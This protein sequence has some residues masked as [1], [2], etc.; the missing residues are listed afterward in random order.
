MSMGDLLDL[1]SLVR[2]SVIMILRYSLFH[3]PSTERMRLD[4]IFKDLPLPALLVSS[5]LLGGKFTYKL[6]WGSNN[7]SQEPSLG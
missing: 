1:A 5:W 7:K 6:T 3:I 4:T 2:L